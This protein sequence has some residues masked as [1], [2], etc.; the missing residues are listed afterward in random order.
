M[1]TMLLD[2]TIWNWCLDASGNIAVATDPYSVAQDVASAVR[3]FI[4]ECYFNTSLG[5]P[6]FQQIFGQLPPL[7]FMK[8]Q[9]CAAAETVPECTNPV[10]YISA[11]SDCK[12][13]GQVQFTDSNGAVQTVSF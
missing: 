12:V 9:I 1:D 11:F 5:I 6:Y 2:R 3:T 4:G 7:A 8:A 10:C 13:A